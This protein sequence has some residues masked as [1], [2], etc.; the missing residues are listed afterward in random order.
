MK[1]VE[2]FKEIERAIPSGN[3]PGK[4]HGLAKVHNAGRPLKV[5]V[6]IKGTSEYNLAKFFGRFDKT[7]YA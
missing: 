6:I 1:N 5:V 4:L 3:N 7:L 2:D